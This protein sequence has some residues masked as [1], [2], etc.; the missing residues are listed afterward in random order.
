MAKSSPSLPAP[1]AQ[2]FVV[3]R[4]IREQSDPYEV[5]L[6]GPRCHVP[7]PMFPSE[8]DLSVYAHIN[9]DHGSY[10]IEI[11][12]RD[13]EGDSVRSWTPPKPLEHPDALEPQQLLLHGLGIFVPRAGRYDLALL[14]GGEEIG[15]QPMIFGTR[16]L[17]GE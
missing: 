6:L 14:A 3:C 10:D 12:L 9:G 1:Q 15:R 16:E 2:A 11:T 13:A 8:V 17:L 5:V 4:D 7:I